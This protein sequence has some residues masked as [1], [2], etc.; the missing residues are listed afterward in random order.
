MA[1]P[2]PR[3]LRHGGDPTSPRRRWPV[4][5]LATAVAVAVVLA[6]GAVVFLA[7]PSGETTHASGT[8]TGSPSPEPPSCQPAPAQLAWNALHT[9]S[10]KFETHA[11]EGHYFTLDSATWGALL[12]VDFTAEFF[13]DGNPD[14][15]GEYIGIWQVDGAVLRP[16]VIGTDGQ[17]DYNN[18]AT[19]FTSNVNSVS[20]PVSD[21]DYI[22]VE[23][24]AGA[25]S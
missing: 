13:G 23:A 19:F 6:V 24:C 5:S 14:G 18:A 11:R 15:P 20:I 2:V 25:G 21:P 10:P 22:R 1:R 8:P 3:A 16:A 17:D 9:G 4:L 12:A 7:W